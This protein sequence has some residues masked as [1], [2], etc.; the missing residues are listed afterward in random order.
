MA[1]TKHKKKRLPHSTVSTNSTPLP[2]SMP[3]QSFAQT[4]FKKRAIQFQ[5]NGSE[6][7]AVYEG[8]DFD[9]IRLKRR[10][11]SVIAVSE[12]V[13]SRYGEICPDVPGLFSLAEDWVL[14]NTYPVSAF[15]HLEQHIYSTLGAAIWILDNIRDQGK[16]DILAEILRCA[17]PAEDVPMP[18]VW[19][20]CHSRQVLRQ[21]VSIINNR[22]R[23]CPATEK[24][25]QKK[26]ASV[27]RIYMD[28][29]TAEN[30][31]DH[32]VPSRLLYDQLIALI[33]P[34][35]LSVIENVYQEKYW[36]WLRRYFLCRAV[37][38]RE[39]QAIRAEVQEFK[40]LTVENQ[41][42]ITAQ[43]KEPA[44]ILSNPITS[45]S[46]IP[47]DFQSLP[48]QQYHAKILEYQNK[49]LREKQEQ[50]RTRFSAFTREVGEFALLPGDEIAKR[51]G[52]ELAQ[53]WE[54]SSP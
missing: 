13:V 28:R 45:G 24:A 41:S 7:D 11:S 32:T 47:P 52:E 36:E 30:K 18:D 3:L 33:D 22:N 29:P 16:T 44:S 1:K 48:V 31:I 42:S 51:Y 35:A 23:D 15:D 10:I 6:V 38:N 34:E 17:P 8:L 54:G 5:K 27:A 9:A 2:G 25:I 40:A 49:S 46:I 12:E 43:T 21:V 19:D 37:F 20:P 50:F 53:I 14:M 39:E 26:R 4:A